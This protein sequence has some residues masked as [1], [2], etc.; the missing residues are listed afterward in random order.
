[1]TDEERSRVN[2]L[3]VLGAAIGLKS[4][5]WQGS[6]VIGPLFWLATISYY[7]LTQ[8]QRK[9]AAERREIYQPYATLGNY[10]K[11]FPHIF[12]CIA[13]AA[14]FTS[15]MTPVDK[16]FFG[17][18]FV[19]FVGWRDINEVTASIMK[20]EQD[21]LVWLQILTLEKSLKGEVVNWS[22]TLEKHRAQQL[23]TAKW[24]TGD[25]SEIVALILVR[26]LV[27]IA[28][29]WLISKLAAVF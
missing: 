15:S 22:E 12:G 24:T 5:D 8:E 25:G 28:V 2:A 3:G 26:Y 9:K 14:L 23:I 17:S 4:F 11:W 19:F 21:S 10:I 13:F 18:A 1:M 27:W 29:G 20:D 7:A 6:L 16:V